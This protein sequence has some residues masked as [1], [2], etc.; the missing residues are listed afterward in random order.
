M[1]DR[2]ER[3]REQLTRL[4]TVFLLVMGAI[5]FAVWPTTVVHRPMQS[6]YAFAVTDLRL[7]SGQADNIVIG[8]ILAVD[9]VDQELGTTSYWIDVT[10]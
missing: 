2:P 3:G 9:D 4:L 6:S 1:A 8:R 7:L 10:M 5:G